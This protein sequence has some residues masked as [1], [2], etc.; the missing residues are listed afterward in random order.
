M[1]MWWEAGGVGLGWV[2]RGER[3]PI[4]KHNVIF[5]MMTPKAVGYQYMRINHDTL[6]TKGKTRWVAMCGWLWVGG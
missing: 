3:V 6:V 1:G 2:G 4:T 5:L